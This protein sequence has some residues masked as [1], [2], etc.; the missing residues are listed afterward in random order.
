VSVAVVM[1]GVLVLLGGRVDDHRF[2]GVGLQ[3]MPR[4]AQRVS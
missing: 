1:A 4:G 3:P 2:G